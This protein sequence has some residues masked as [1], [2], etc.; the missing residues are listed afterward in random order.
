MQFTR[1]GGT[2]PDAQVDHFHEPLDHEGDTD[3]NQERQGQNLDG[4]MSVNEIP[5]RF[6]ANIVTNNCVD[7][8]SFL[9]R[10][11]SGLSILREGYAS[12]S[13]WSVLNMDYMCEWTMTYSCYLDKNKFAVL[14]NRSVRGV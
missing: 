4:R 3:Q 5:N 1:G 12:A 8:Y 7:C 6:E 13:P 14:A 11:L 10:I 2:C 9:V